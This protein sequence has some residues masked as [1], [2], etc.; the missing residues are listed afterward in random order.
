M[1][2]ATI[3][4]VQT[5]RHGLIYRIR[6]N[7]VD[8]A[9]GK[10]LRPWETLPP[11]TTSKQVET[12]RRRGLTALDEGRMPVATDGTVAGLLAEWLK[13][14]I[15]PRLEPTTVEGYEGT[16]TNHLVP[17]LGHLPL[18]KVTPAVAQ[19][20]EVEYRE[21]HGYRTVQLCHLRLKQA[22]SWGVRMGHM[23]YNP[24]DDVRPPETQ[25]RP[26]RM[27][28]G[29]EARAFLAVAET[30]GYAPLWHFLLGTGVRRGEALGLRWSD[31]D[32]K[33]GTARIEQTIRP[34]HGKTH[35]KGTKNPQSVR[36]VPVHKGLLTRLQRHRT[37]QSTHRLKMGE[38]Y[39]DHDLVFASNVGTAINPNNVLRAFLPLVAKAGVTRITLHQLRHTAASLALD[40]GM[41][42]EQIRQLLGH[43]K[44]STTADI[45]ARVTEAA[46]QT[47]AESLGRAMGD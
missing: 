4:E 3:H 22:C 28:T 47:V 41:T 19:R 21:T 20:W 24:L 12:A 17:A 44:I 33:A 30:D 25:A 29:D 9:T 18:R 37:K 34:L 26:R 14:D 40:A 39:R 8:P 35:P 31:I 16:V 23:A 27:W 38:A 7:Y 45:Y 15:R 42:L 36:R 2:S 43:K 32:W 6:Y 1:A 13:L 46:M 5:K 11:G 10:R